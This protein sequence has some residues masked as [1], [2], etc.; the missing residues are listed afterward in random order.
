MYFP[1]Q[2]VFKLISSCFKLFSSCFQVVF[3]LF[4][5]SKKILV[6]MLFSSCFQVVFFKLFG[7]STLQIMVIYHIIYLYGGI[8]GGEMKYLKWRRLYI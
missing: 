7:T 1:D 3:K 8:Y 5:S 4:S 6:F 2:V